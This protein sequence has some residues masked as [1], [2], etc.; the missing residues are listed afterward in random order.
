M[1]CVLVALL[2]FV[3]VSQGE[4][5]KCHCGGQY[6]CPGNEETCDADQI[7]CVSFTFSDGRYPSVVRGCSSFSDCRRLDS[8]GIS[9]SSCCFSDLCNF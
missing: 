5:L 3:I 4:A 6:N 2:V 8:P 1:K 9:T 7:Y